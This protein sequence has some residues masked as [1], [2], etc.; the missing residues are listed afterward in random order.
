MIGYPAVDSF[1]ATEL[2]HGRPLYDKRPR[3]AKAEKAFAIQKLECTITGVL[4][5]PHAPGPHP[6]YYL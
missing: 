6:C 3:K 4:A 5:L 1:T 2:S